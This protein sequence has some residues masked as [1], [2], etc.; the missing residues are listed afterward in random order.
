MIDLV[1]SSLAHKIVTSADVMLG[2]MG[3]DVLAKAK[4]NILEAA[5]AVELDEAM[6]E[7][8]RQVR[9]QREEEERERR[10]QIEAN[11]QYHTLDIDPFGKNAQGNLRKK[12]RG[13]R[14][15]FGKFR[16][17]LVEDVPTWYL[18]SCMSGK[19]FISVAWLRSAIKKELN[20]R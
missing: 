5:Q 10:K 17:T 11:A 19:P 13:A 6:L 1:D 14:M 16:G 9:E 18:E 8:Q 15:L 2:D 7:A 20:K 4:E 3:L 12:K